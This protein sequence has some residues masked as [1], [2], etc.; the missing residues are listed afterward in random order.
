MNHITNHINHPGLVE[1]NTLHV[2]TMVSNPA[3]WHSRYRLARQFIEEMNNTPNVKLHLVE[4]AHGDRHHELETESHLRLRTNSEIWQ[5]ENAI[6]LGVRHLLP[7]NFRYMSWVD[8][9]IHFRDPHWAQET[10][11]KLQT[12]AVVQPWQQCTD[13]GPNGNVMQLHQSFGWLHRSGKQKQK[14]FGDPYAYAH[15]GFAWACTRAFW[16]ATQGLPDHC[17][18][19]SADHHAAWAMIGDG[20]W[21]VHRAMGPSYGRRI[22]EWQDRAVRATHKQV[23]F[24]C[25][26]IEHN[27]HG[28]KAAR[29]YRERWQ[30]LIDHK[31]DPEKDLAYDGQGLIQLYGK[32]ALEHEIISYNRNRSEDSIDE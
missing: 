28:S 21:T 22:K 2:V 32:P 26:R 18:L 14:G 15:T 10:I 11:S 3:R 4:I 16:E 13:L 17:I 30:I 29:K 25:G 19:G 20:E 1:D 31:F 6:N 23:G 5:K 27:F 8:A 12:Y 24:T 7:R 9:D